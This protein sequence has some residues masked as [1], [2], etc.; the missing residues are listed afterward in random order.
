MSNAPAESVNHRSFHCFRPRAPPERS[1]FIQPLFSPVI[2]TW[3]PLTPPPL[4]YLFSSGACH[5]AHRVSALSLC[6]CYGGPPPQKAQSKRQ[7]LKSVRARVCVGGGG[8]TQQDGVYRV[9]QG[10]SH[11][12]FR[13]HQRP[14]HHQSC[15]QT[16]CFVEA[17][18]SRTVG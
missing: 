15:A 6:S 11:R 2:V 13:L 12:C 18:S 8:G 3:A 1:T 9:W 10:G 17:P 14:P 7:L 4:L 16:T 5:S